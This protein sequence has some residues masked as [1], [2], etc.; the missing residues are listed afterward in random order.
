MTTS[1]SLRFL[2]G[3]VA[4]VALALV[5]AE[6]A[7]ARPR[8]RS[9]RASGCASVPACAALSP[10]AKRAFATL[11][12]APVFA[13]EAVGGELPA[14]VVALRILILDPNA[15]AAVDH[16]FRNA[17]PA[18][19]LYAVVAYWRVAPNVF[20]ARRESLIHTSG[21]TQVTTQLGS[22]QHVTT[23]GEV[24]QR[25]EGAHPFP[26]GTQRLDAF[27][28]SILRHDELA[29]QSDYAAGGSTIEMLDGPRTSRAECEAW[30]ESRRVQPTP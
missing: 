5:L 10:D 9:R 19:K 22:N 27:C 17:S 8:S 28:P 21:A 16:L 12:A 24:L 11:L 29:F 2:F 6:P 1:R 7:A 3:F 25:H 30:Q 20:H 4:A 23:I 14:E 18:G 15:L 26:P 13:T